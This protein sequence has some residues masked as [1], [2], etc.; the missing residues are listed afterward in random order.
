[1]NEVETVECYEHTR[2]IKRNHAIVTNISSLQTEIVMKTT[3]SFPQ[4]R[5][6][7]SL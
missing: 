2:R 3:T 7:E 6:R 5:M 4:L 1:M